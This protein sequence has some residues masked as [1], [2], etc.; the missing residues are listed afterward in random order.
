MSVK[1]NPDL[2]RER[3]SATFNVEEMAILIHQG[4]EMLKRKRKAGMYLLYIRCRV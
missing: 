3:A 4:A 1:V 2:E